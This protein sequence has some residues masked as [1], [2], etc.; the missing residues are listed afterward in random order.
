MAQTSQRRRLVPKAAII[1]SV[2]IVILAGTAVV[3]SLMVTRSRLVEVPAVTGLPASAAQDT[4]EAEGLVYE[5]G[6]TRVSPTV[7][8]GQVI[9]QDPDPGALLDPGSVVRVVLSVGPQT[10]KVPDLVGTSVEGARDALSALGLTVVVEAV[11]SDT[12]ETIVLEMYPAPGSSVSP[13]DEIRLSVPGGSDRS[14]VL[15]P[16]D[17]TGMTVLLDPSP[18]PAGSDTDASMEVAR[19]LQAL[20]VAAGA[21]VTS[22]R[23]PA[24][25][26]SSPDRVTAAGSSTADILVG[27]DIG[28]S[29]Q[30]GLRVLYQPQTDG[31]AREAASMRYAQAITRAASLPTLVVREPAP[32]SDAVLSAFPGPGVRIEIG[33]ASVDADRALFRD[34]SWADQVARA[35]YRGVGPTL[36]D[37]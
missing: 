25:A 1:A 11:S 32:V 9:S 30:G 17:L 12:T 16:Y 3:A 36:S 21:E 37:T 23:P 20:F 27:I 4:I 24:G 28:V 33:D 34:P 13:G 2:V 22:T 35:I 6:G 15:L 5:L 31:G 10:F 7:P 26:P 29:G 14:D 19:R 8:S 18:A